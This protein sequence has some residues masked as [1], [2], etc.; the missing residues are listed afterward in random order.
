MYIEPMCGILRLCS[1]PFLR[2]KSSDEI[3]YEQIAVESISQLG[4][5]ESFVAITAFLQLFVP[6]I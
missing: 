1:L 2:E 6:L 4:M 5:F 3:S